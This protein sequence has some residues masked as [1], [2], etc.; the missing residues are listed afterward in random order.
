MKTLPVNNDRPQRSNLT[1]PNVLS[2]LRLAS[3]PVLLWLAWTGRG[4]AYLIAFVVI[5]AT[6]FLDG[7]L[8][9][10]LKQETEL[11]ATLDQLADVAALLTVPLAML[12]N[13]PEIL[14]Q[15]AWGLAAVI[16][17]YGASLAVSALKFGR[18]A[19]TH[20]WF[21][22]TST[23]T[24]A[25]GAV[26]AMLDWADWPFRVGL[27]LTAL[28][29]LEEIAITLTLPIARSNVPTLWHAW[30]FRRLHQSEVSHSKRN[31]PA[32]P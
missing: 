1:I 13:W 11:G 10:R 23:S 30:R 14:R 9:R 19:T 5:Y 25:I 27:V 15:E 20:A 4:R 7:L 18:V 22:K 17:L 2:S 26:V 21:G 16:G 8:A 32:S 29:C 31:P 24:L 6:D 3:V 28:A 12:W